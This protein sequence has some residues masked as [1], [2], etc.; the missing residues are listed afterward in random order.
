MHVRG[1]LINILSFFIQRFVVVC[2]VFM[3]AQA[4]L[5]ELA[6]AKPR[7]PT[8]LILYDLSS[9]APVHWPPNPSMA[10]LFT[11]DL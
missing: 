2:L 11:S 8:A 6:H 3:S 9:E 4:Q 10:A 7:L 1:P 5:R